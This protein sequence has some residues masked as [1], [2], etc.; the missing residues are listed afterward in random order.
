MATSNEQ[1]P[2][3]QGLYDRGKQNGVDGLSLLMGDQ[4]KEIEPYCEVFKKKGFAL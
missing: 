3:L 4:I 2:A 1:V